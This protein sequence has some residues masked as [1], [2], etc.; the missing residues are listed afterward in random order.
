[1]Y[2][3]NRYIVSVRLAVLNRTRKNTIYLI[4]NNTIIDIVNRVR[5]YRITILVCIRIIYIRYKYYSIVG[6]RHDTLRIAAFS[7]ARARNLFRERVNAD[8]SR[9]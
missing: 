9:E 5:P 6:T 1:M 3:R 2:Q 4:Y 7:R 8:A